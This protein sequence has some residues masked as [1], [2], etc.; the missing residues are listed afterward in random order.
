MAQ[1]GGIDKPGRRQLRLQ[2]ATG[3]RL[4]VHPQHHR[5]IDQRTG[6]PGIG[7]RVGGRGQRGR[8][9]QAD[10]AHAGCAQPFQQFGQAL[11]RPGRRPAG[12]QAQYHYRCGRLRAES[13][14]GQVVQQAPQ[15][16]QAAQRGRRAG[17]QGQ[18]EEAP[19]RRWQVG[20]AHPGRPQARRVDAGTHPP[21]PHWPGKHCIAAMRVPVG[22]SPARPV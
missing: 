22:R 16:Q 3:V 18:Q 17:T 21:R 19:V 2:A 7:H 8:Q 9:V 11:V 14:Q 20:A 12:V 6:Q 4:Q 13:A 1:A 5:A 10:A 15:A